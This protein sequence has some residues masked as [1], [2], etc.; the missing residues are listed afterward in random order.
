V[1][2]STPVLTT[3]GVLNTFCVL[4]L[5]L[6]AASKHSEAAEAFDRAAWLAGSVEHDEKTQAVR[7]RLDAM[8][9]FLSMHHEY[10]N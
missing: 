9:V 7:V 5:A 2:T 4:H 1:R 6:Q 10:G 3:F 8:R